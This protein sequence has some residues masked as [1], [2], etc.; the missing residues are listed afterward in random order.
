M[1]CYDCQPSVRDAVA[2][3]GLCGKGLCM[4]HHVRLERTVFEHVPSGMTAQIRQT[5]R[6]IPRML[7]QEC[8]R[9]VGTADVGHRIDMIR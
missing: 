1:N 2:V 4:D 8:A 3:C 5:G 6:A 7:C 9:G